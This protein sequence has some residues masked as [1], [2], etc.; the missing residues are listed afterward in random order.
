MPAASFPSLRFCLRIDLDE[1]EGKH[2]HHKNGMPLDDRPENLEVMGESEH[3]KL[4]APDEPP[5]RPEPEK[6]RRLAEER[7]RD[8]K[9]RFI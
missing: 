4:H 8:E 5:K 3:H 6:M 7:E 1:M 9:G 2:V